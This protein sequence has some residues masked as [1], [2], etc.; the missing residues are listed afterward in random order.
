[1]ASWYG[2]STWYGQ[3]RPA[4]AGGEGDGGVPT[5]DEDHR[6]ANGKTR[7]ECDGADFFACL[8]GGV[9]LRQVGGRGRVTSQDL[10]DR[11]CGEEDFGGDRVAEAFEVR[12][13]FCSVGKPVERCVVLID[14]Q[15]AVLV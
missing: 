8:T 1:M 15:V 4:A 3:G 9:E 5:V 14:E 13:G 10:R 12:G 2:E 11:V 6:A 7:C